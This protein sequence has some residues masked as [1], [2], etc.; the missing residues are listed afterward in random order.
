M[1]VLKCTH[2]EL[3]LLKIINWAALS[4][5]FGFFCSHQIFRQELEKQENNIDTRQVAYQHDERT[6]KKIDP[7]PKNLTI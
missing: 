1:H 4:F 3:S 5:S 2:C 7:D 6:L